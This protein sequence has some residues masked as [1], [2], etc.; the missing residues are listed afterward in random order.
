MLLM[1][2]MKTDAFILVML[3]ETPH[4]DLIKDKQFLKLLPKIVGI[5]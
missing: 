3:P 4:F 1:I 2:D 5:A